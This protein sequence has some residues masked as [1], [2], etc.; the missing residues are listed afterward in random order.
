MSAVTDR[1]I[2]QDLAGDGLPYFRFLCVISGLESKLNLTSSVLKI[3][4]SKSTYND[5]ENKQAYD[6]SVS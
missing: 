6:V 2:K 4:I 3:A 5:N 1:V